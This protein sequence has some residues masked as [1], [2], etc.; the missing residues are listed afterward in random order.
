MM[1][2]GTALK[3]GA[4][5]TVF[6]HSGRLGKK[7]A[8]TG[9]GRCNV[10]NNCTTDEFIQNVMSN[11][12]FMYAPISEFSTQDTM[13][14]FEGLG[15]PLKTERGRRVFPE[16]DK[17]SDIVSAM[18][19]QIYGAKIVFENVKSIKTENSKAVGVITENGEY[20]FD[21][22]II[23]TGG[24]SYP[25][26][27]SDGSG[28]KLAAA[29]GHRITAI[30]PSLVPIEANGDICSRMQGL[31]L[32]NTKVTVV[33]ENGNKIYEDFGELLFTHFGISGPTVLSATAH[34]GKYDVGTLSF[35]LDLKP[36]LDEKT[37]DARILSDFSK[38]KNRDFGNALSGLLPSKM[39]ALIPQIVQIPSD[40]KVNEITKDE[41][42]RLV[43]V[44]KSFK[45]TL[46]RL[47]P[48]DEAIV[49][50]GGVDTKEISPKTMQSKLVS[51]L[52][53][54]GEVIDVD[55]YT[56]GY[57]LQIAFSTGYVAGLNASKEDNASC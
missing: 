12:R 4:E 26:T 6:E 10:T 38:A 30:K 21:R 24:K 43:S 9:K 37:L 8:I 17:A 39:A 18:K 25:L 23:A 40:K 15:V 41:R 51:S 11:P 55:A 14:F 45:I 34:L 28:Y 46:K 44:L 48:I 47:R 50:R 20:S 57:N 32:K 27:G 19:R 52:Y 13:S 16:S 31:S 42:K 22:I 36:A 1:A 56:G 35:I 5:V 33:D 49:T 54:A 29:L 53:F 3:N 7:L 2:A